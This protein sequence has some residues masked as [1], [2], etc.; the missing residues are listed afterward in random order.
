MERITPVDK[1]FDKSY[2]R[3]DWEFS[4]N[5]EDFER[6]CRDIDGKASQKASTMNKLMKGKGTESYE[7]AAFEDGIGG[8]C[9]HC[10][11]VVTNYVRSHYVCP[12]CHRLTRRLVPKCK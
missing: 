12:F 6:L 8:Q 7:A 3:D 1:L 4:G 9:R 11:T 5:D 2:K 10:G